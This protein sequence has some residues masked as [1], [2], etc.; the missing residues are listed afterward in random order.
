MIG[1]FIITGDASK[2]VIIRAIG[3]SMND[4]GVINVL[5]DPI[6]TLHGPDGSLLGSN[7]NWRENPA[8]AAEIEA[9]GIPPE[10]DLESAIAAT[11][12]AAAYTAV[13]HGTGQSSGVA[14]VEVYDLE[15]G[16]ASRLANVSTRGTV[17]S[18]ESVMI[19]G[20]VLGGAGTGSPTIVVRALGPSL[21]QAG[22]TDTLGDPN[23]E[24]RDGNGSLV[25]ANDDW[26]DNAQQANELSQSALAPQESSEAA[27][28]LRV[29]PGA[30]TAIVS[31][32]KGGTG[33]A[34]IEGYDLG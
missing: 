23:L 13:V 30:Y 27:I 4:D 10:H 33:V 22:V 12:P 6:V 8:Q 5:A 14:L 31:G 1:G 29:P 17:I 16:G 3:P 20:F 34:M 32:A 24:L 9:S 25:L 7:D 19:G 2:R 26:Q 21:S 18:G 15:Q 11:L 28:I